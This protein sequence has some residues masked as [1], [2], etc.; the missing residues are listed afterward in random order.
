MKRILLLVTMVFTVV[1][2]AQQI[3]NDIKPPSWSMTSLDNFRAHKLPSFD[4]KTLQEEDVINDL[5][6]SKP[7]RFGHELYVDHDINS[8]GNWTTLD[9]G[10][11]IW[12]MNYKS[13]GANT[14]NFMFDTFYLPIGAKLYVYNDDKTDLIRP[15]T[16]HNNNPEEVLG[17]WLVNGD[18]AWIELYEPANV[19]GQSR[20][21]VGSVV[22]GYRTL[23][24]FQKALN[25]SGPCNQDVDCDITPASDPFQLNTR[26]EEVKKAVGMMVTGANGFCTGTLVNN[27]NNDGTPYFL[28]ANH[29]GGGE[30]GW[31][32]RFNWRS[33]NPSCGTNTNS[34][35]GSWNQTVSGS[36]L[37]AASSQSD[38]E[39][40]QINDT[41]F[42]N[43]NPDV[44]WA[45]WN[46]S[47]S[48]IPNT[49][50]GIHHPSGDIQK[51]CR[52]DQAPSRVTTGFNG[53]PD[54]QMWLVSDWDL[55]V[56]EPGSSGSGLFDQNG[57]I[58]GM[59][60]GGSAACAGTNDNGGS[61]IY[62]RF[63]VAWNFGSNAASRLSDWLDPGNTGATTV[64][65]F[66]TIQALAND[67]S[68]NAGANVTSELC[69]TAFTPEVTLVNNGTNTLN[70]ATI[71]YNL[72]SGT[73]SVVNW[74]GSLTEG[75][76]TIVATPSYNN[77]SAGAHSFS[78]TVSN[79]N[80]G[81]TDE[82]PANDSFTFNFNV[83][84]AF[85]TNNVILN[86]LTDNYGG[87]TSWELRNSSDIVV[88]SGPTSNYANGTNY[89]ETI[90]IPVLDECYTFTIFDS[91]GDGICCAFGTGSYSL[92]DDNGNIIISGGEF[93]SSE[94]IIFSALNPLSI[95]EFGLESVV[96]IYPNPVKN[97]LNIDLNI[98]E[99]VNYEIINLLGQSLLKGSFNV[100]G[101]HTLDMSQQES[102]VYFIKL[103]SGNSSFTKKIVKK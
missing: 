36:T 49:T 19:V 45:G 25:D 9:N 15:F 12:R 94:S 70:S 75:Q 28:T 80:G 101:N 78:I 30:A 72:D 57:R 7:W 59:L 63:G 44:V 77:L 81:V 16:H 39:L 91:Y 22:H 66:P 86:I 31:A 46:R 69:G 24:S 26:K 87:E 84:P 11:R 5:D 98:S 14:L 8:Y 65:I 64:D 29:C 92:E 79:I 100:G 71:T 61:D 85:A 93:N 18:H 62:G 50:F 90:A 21:V 41:N 38:M 95:N 83:S 34:T 97:K 55:G 56:T 54:A 37:R 48:Q 17:T 27:T 53:D 74:T 102:G 2:F 68:V 10:D 35:N 42:F 32:F 33:P 1:S 103:T 47:T 3:P 51:T 52:D 96:R 60:S 73:N 23:N 67:A 20:I 6:K 40:V 76:N 89:Q 99:D 13:D 4:L 43:N 88:S 58:V 82:N